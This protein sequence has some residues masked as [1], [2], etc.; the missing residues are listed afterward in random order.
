MSHNLPDD[1]HVYTYYCEHCNTRYHYIDGG[2]SCTPCE[3]VTDGRACENYEGRCP[4]HECYECGEA[5]VDTKPDENWRIDSRYCG[6]CKP[7]LFEE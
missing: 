2:C 3:G 5:G 4:D 1:W 6:D 7:E